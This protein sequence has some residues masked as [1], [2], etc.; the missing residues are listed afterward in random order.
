M[1]HPCKRWYGY[2][3]KWHK[4]LYSEFQVATGGEK[5]KYHDGQLYGTKQCSECKCFSD[6]YDERDHPKFAT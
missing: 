4:A 6:G 5:P 2:H 3:H 1:K